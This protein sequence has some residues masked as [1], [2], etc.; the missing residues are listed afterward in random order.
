MGEKLSFIMVAVMAAALAVAMLYAGQEVVQDINDADTIER[1]RINLTQAV[2]DA[3][4]YANGKAARVEL[5]DEGGEPVYRVKVINGGKATDVHVDG[6][7]GKILSM[8]GNQ[9]DDLLT[10]S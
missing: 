3:E 8:Q 2:S 9:A 7:T 5:K 6:K 10:G 1:T 4:R